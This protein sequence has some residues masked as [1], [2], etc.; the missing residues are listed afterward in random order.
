M[1]HDPALHQ[2]G[3]TAG[4][5][6]FVTS[7]Y[8][9]QPFLTWRGRELSYGDMRHEVAALGE[10]LKA[11]GLR[12][13]DGVA[14]LSSNTPE[15]LFAREA[16][17]AKG[18]FYV[19][20]SPFS[21]LAD[22]VA[23]IEDFGVKGVV[24]DD[25]EQSE[26]LGAL[27]AALPGRIVVGFGERTDGSGLSAIA[28]PFLGAPYRIEC[29]ADDLVRLA[30]TGGTTGRPK[31]VQ[32]THRAAL[33]Y[34]LM[35]HASWDLPTNMRFLATTPLSHAAGAYVSQT[36]FRGGRF[37]MLP[38]FTPQA[39]EEA[40]WE[41][42]INCT[43]LVP[44][45]MK[46]ILQDPDVNPAVIGG[47]ETIAY[48][49]APIAPGILEAWLRR[50]GPNVS[51]LYGQAESPMCITALRKGLHS[52][53]YPHR[54]A[55]C[56]LPNIGMQVAIMRSDGSLAKDDERG[57]VVARGPAVMDGYWQRLSETAEA[58]EHGWLHTG[59]LGYRDA[60]GFYYI[61]GRAKEMIITGGVNVY[62][63]EIE[64]LLAQHESVKDV[65]VIGVPDADWGE[66][67]KAFI[68][69]NPGMSLEPHGLAA[70]V[71]ERKGA[72][73]TPKTFE[74]IEAI[75]VTPVGKP[76]KKALRAPYWEEHGREVA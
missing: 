14:F 72:V 47:I 12:R 49:A 4:M 25:R 71:R 39:F 34:A 70:L 13:G 6:D 31:G 75:P 66:A 11:M 17:A 40:V 18:I 74:A 7:A 67:V 20:L 8:L 51:Q 76:D 43:M 5:F 38:K 68:V 55:S 56:G 26:A 73:Y 3:T 19:S 50:F 10:A 9:D 53:D 59:D 35:C 58:F 45:Q 33:S 16:A 1:A 64:D 52:L 42:R 65:A 29:E 37:F 69:L 36:M 24:V 2:F 41:H 48:G 46:R 54:L 63:K 44:T 28:V 30:Q 60:D 15:T 32:L 62:P 27:A 22:Q 61:V 23:L 21:A 57:E